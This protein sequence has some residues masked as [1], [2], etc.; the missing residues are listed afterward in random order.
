MVAGSETNF[1]K[2][3]EQ[4]DYEKPL[5]GQWLRRIQSRTLFRKG[6]AIFQLIEFIGVFLRRAGLPVQNCKGM[7]QLQRVPVDRLC[8]LLKDSV[9]LA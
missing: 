3:N 9:L 1:S 4:L 2:N 5:F 7:L 6:H 8:G